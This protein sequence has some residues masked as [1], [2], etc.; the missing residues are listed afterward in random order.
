MLTKALP[1]AARLGSGGRMA[2]FSVGRMSS[3]DASK[4]GTQP[5]QIQAP[6]PTWQD[7]TKA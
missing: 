5:Q 6:S 2:A 1:A 4:S 3:S 7:L